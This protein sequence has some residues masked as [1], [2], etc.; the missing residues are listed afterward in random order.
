M[1]FA[2]FTLYCTRFAHRFELSLETR[3]SFLHAAAINFQLRFAWS[4]RADPTRLS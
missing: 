4:A 1:P 3:N 2:S